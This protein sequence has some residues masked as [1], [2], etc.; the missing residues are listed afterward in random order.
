MCTFSD[1]LEEKSA[2]G[3]RQAP[4]RQIECGGG[5]QKIEIVGVLIAAGDAA[6]VLGRVPNLV[7]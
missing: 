2:P 7:H 5:T 6:L 3:F 1:A 4:E